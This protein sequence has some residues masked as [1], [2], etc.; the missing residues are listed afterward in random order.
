VV[1][2]GSPPERKTADDDENAAWDIEKGLGRPRKT[3]VIEHSCIV[4]DIHGHN[5]MRIMKQRWWAMAY[6]V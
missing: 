5:A 3:I 4:A 1:E 2:G 6:A